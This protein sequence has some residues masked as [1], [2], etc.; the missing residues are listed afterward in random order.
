[1]YHLAALILK[2]AAFDHHPVVQEI[3]RADSE[4]RRDGPGFRV[5]SAVDESRNPRV[6]DGSRA[7]RARFDSRIQGR[8]RKPVI[9]HVP[10]R[11]S[12]SDYLGVSGRVAQADDGVSP[13]AYDRAFKDDD[14]PYGHLAPKPRR[15]GLRKRL[16][17]EFV[18]RRH[19]KRIAKEIS[20]SY[21]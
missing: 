10:R 9:G 13:P 1:L 18:I 4:M 20:L 8:T 7:H 3:C 15:E 17:H 19:R 14:C 5:V 2:D 11:F 16:S 21:H 12:E 6:Q